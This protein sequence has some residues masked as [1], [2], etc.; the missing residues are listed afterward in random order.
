ME[1]LKLYEALLAD[2]A[3][4]FEV[5]AETYRQLA[6]RENTAANLGLAAEYARHAW[7]IRDALE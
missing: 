2:A 3:A 6:K 7:V 1:K 4:S 5:Q